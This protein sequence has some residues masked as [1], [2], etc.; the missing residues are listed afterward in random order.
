[1]QVGVAHFTLHAH[2]ALLFGAVKNCDA[3]PGGEHRTSVGTFRNERRC[4]RIADFEHTG[5]GVGGGQRQANIPSCRSGKGHVAVRPF[6][7]GQSAAV[8]QSQIVH[9]GIG[10]RRGA[11]MQRHGHLASGSQAIAHGPGEVVGHCGG[12]LRRGSERVLPVAYPQR[13]LGVLVAFAGIG[14]IEVACKGEGGCRYQSRRGKPPVQHLITRH[15]GVEVYLPVALYAVHFRFAEIHVIQRVGRRGDNRIGRGERQGV[16]RHGRRGVGEK[17]ISAP[18]IDMAGGTFEI[19]VDKGFLPFARRFGRQEVHPFASY[20][21]EKETGAV[22]QHRHGAE[23][24]V[25]GDGAVLKHELPFGGQCAAA[26]DRHAPRVAE[27]EARQHGVGQLVNA[28]GVYRHFH[29]PAFGEARPGGE[30]SR[31]KSENSG[32]SKCGRK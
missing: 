3:R 2:A 4:L 23:V 31:G 12:N 9:T 5:I 30:V 25:H 13:P 8:G 17:V 21:V 11:D 19:P 1:M 16:H 26:E 32:G 24:A 10:H 29:P 27:A 14:G 18:R 20:A 6:G 22:G 15:Y 28:G 7:G